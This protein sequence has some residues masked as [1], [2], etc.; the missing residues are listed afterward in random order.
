LDT[1]LTVLAQLFRWSA[2]AVGVFYGVSHQAKLSTKDKLENAQR[3]YKH[4]EDLISQAK[5]EW[6]RLHPQSSSGSGS[7]DDIIPVP[8]LADSK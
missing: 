6:A 1:P 8:G 3:E 2:L 5:A 4:K 7:D